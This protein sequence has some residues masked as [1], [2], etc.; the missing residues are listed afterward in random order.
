MTSPT[1]DEMMYCEKHPDREAS[2]RC[3]RCGRLMCTQ[4]IVRSPTGYIC[5]ECAS[6]FEDKFFHGT[7]AD[8]WIHGAV[9]FFGLAVAAAIVWQTRI[10][11]YL[12]FSVFIGPVVGGGVAELALRLTQRRRGR[13]S[14]RIG[15]AAAAAGAVI[16]SFLSAYQYA[17]SL[18]G[19]LQRGVLPA[20]N[21]SQAVTD[22]SQIAGSSVLQFALQA[23]FTDLGF[24]VF[25][26]LAVGAV[27]AR[28]QVRI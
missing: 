17:A 10:A 18:I 27:Y 16:G 7:N 28:F 6:G 15:T 9:C 26:A 19:S 24:L 8:Y 13:Y 23:V 4:C 25:L 14:D 20:T 11:S 22:A 1:A 2:L 12:V 5:K 21:V 3:I